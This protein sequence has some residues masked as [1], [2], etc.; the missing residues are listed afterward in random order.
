MIVGIGD[1]SSPIV[2]VQG[3]EMSFCADHWVIDNSYCLHN[4]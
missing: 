3:E 1:L 4:F 2:L